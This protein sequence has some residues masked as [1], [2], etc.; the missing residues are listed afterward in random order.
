M[1]TMMTMMLATAKLSSRCTKYDEDC[2]DIDVE[3]YYG[4]DDD[5]DDDD[6][7]RAKLS[8]RCTKYDEDS[9]DIDE[10]D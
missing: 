6:D 10:H 8:S 1:T 4:N 2:D 7:N 5:D 3:N 9:D